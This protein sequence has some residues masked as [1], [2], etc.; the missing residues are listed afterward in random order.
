L[1][2]IKMLECKPNAQSIRLTESI[3]RSHTVDVQE[4]Y[5]T[6]IPAFFLKIS[7]ICLF[8]METI[9]FV[10]IYNSD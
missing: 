7:Q 3:L 6:K 2:F 8:A 1:F 10:R 5:P 9:D 4:N